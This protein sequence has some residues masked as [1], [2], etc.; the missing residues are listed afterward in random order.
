[1]FKLSSFVFVGLAVVI[2]TS[3][4]TGCN[5]DSTGSYRETVS[6]IPSSAPEISR[7]SASEQSRPLPSSQS[8]PNRDTSIDAAI[9][10]QKAI[11]RQLDQT[12]VNNGDE[13]LRRESIREHQ[14]YLKNTR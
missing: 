5:S 14:D 10:Q 3:A 12:K 8:L 2:T 9:K 6:P 4:L 7:P 11:N 13:A 1:M